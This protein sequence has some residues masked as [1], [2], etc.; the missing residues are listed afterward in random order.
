M[1]QKLLTQTLNSSG[2]N[3]RK[4]VYSWRQYSG[5]HVTCVD[6]CEAS[7]VLADRSADVRSTRARSA[8]DVEIR[9][10]FYLTRR[11]SYPHSS[12][13]TLQLPALAACFSLLAAI[14]NTMK[15]AMLAVFAVVALAAVSAGKPHLA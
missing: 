10:R 12:L 6:A 3:A 15:A 2:G 1:G 4:H 8:H 11:K 5:N 13:A 7:R 14:S 9:A